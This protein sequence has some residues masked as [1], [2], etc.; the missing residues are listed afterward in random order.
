M[1]PLKV[2]RPRESTYLIPTSP[3]L[4]RHPTPAACCAQFLS[5]PIM[6]A[7]IY[8][9]RHKTDLAPEWPVPNASRSQSALNVSAAENREQT[10]LECPLRRGEDSRNEAA[11]AVGSMPADNPLRFAFGSGNSAYTRLLPTLKRQITLF[12]SKALKRTGP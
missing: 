8:A 2:V 4:H 5:A 11:V 7:R 10:E 9:A 3:S 1:E 6:T 12:S